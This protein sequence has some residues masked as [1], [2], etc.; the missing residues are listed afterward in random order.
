MDPEW[1]KVNNYTPSAPEE[2]DVQVI[3]MTDD[4]GRRQA[5]LQAQWEIKDDGESV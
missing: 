2:P 1:L 4:E 3:T 5:V